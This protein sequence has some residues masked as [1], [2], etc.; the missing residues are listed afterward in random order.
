MAPGALLHNG[1]SWKACTIKR[2]L[3]LV[4]IPKQSMWQNGVVPLLLPILNSKFNHVW[5]ICLALFWV[6]TILSKNLVFFQTGQSDVVFINFQ[7]FHVAV[8]WKGCFYSAFVWKCTYMCKHRFGV[9]LFQNS[10]LC[11]ST[12]PGTSKCLDHM[13]GCHRCKAI[14]VEAI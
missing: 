14:A 6:N 1:E 9:Q 11:S 2:C 7:T 12:A 8:V 10:P 13:L 5:V 3:T 4:C